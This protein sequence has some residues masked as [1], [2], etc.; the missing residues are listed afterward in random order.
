MTNLVRYNDI[1]TMITGKVAVTGKKCLCLAGVAWT[2][3]NSVPVSGKQRSEVEY[4]DV[5]ENW[6]HESVLKEFHKG[7]KPN[8]DFNPKA[9]KNTHI[10][11]GK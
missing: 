1:Y 4:M 2:S 6:W 5:D 9:A 8:P 10:P 7:G 11:V 3:L